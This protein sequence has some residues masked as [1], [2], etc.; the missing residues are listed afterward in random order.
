M[1]KRIVSLLMTILIIATMLPVQALAAELAN[2]SKA[3]EDEIVLEEEAVIS[4]EKKAPEEA[5]QDL[6]AVCPVH[7]TV[8]VPCGNGAHCNRSDTDHRL[9]NVRF[10]PAT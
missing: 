3:T 8:C 5:P 1:R 4:P 10:Y 7:G 9:G 2:S 6:P